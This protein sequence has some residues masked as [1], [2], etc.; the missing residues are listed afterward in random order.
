MS[1]KKENKMKILVVDDS[2]EQQEAAR[3]TLAEHEL[4]IVST[5]DAARKLLKSEFDEKK[6]TVLMEENGFP[7]NYDY[8]ED[9]N[10]D[11]INLFLQLVERCYARPDFDA[12]LTD[13]LLPTEDEGLRPDIY[14]KYKGQLIPYGFAIAN[15]AVQNKVKN[16]AVVSLGD[17]HDHPILWFCDSLHGMVTSGFKIF[18]FDITMKESEF[19]KIK[20]TRK[21]KDWGRAL[22]SLL[23]G[24]LF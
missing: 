15:L 4:I 19:P 3:L 14:R 12:V 21:L 18:M 10:K 23:K 24:E 17:H 16:V 7:K 13:L 20:N 11:R 1:G 22:R 6:L 8:T 2:R 9:T 5:A